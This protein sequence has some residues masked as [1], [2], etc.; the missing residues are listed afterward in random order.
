[1]PRAHRRLGWIRILLWV[2]W[3]VNVVAQ[4]TPYLGTPHPVPGLIEAEHYDLGGEGVAY[5]GLGLLTTNS[6]VKVKFPTGR[7]GDA[8]PQSWSNVVLRTGEWLNFSVQCQRDGHY[9]L[10]VKASG[11]PSYQERNSWPPDTFNTYT[12]EARVHFDVDGQRATEEIHL[13]RQD[14]CPRIWMSAGPHQVRLVVDLVSDF[15]EHRWVDDT[16]WWTYENGWPWFSF[17]LD[18]IQLRPA[19]APLFA[20]PVAG[21]QNGFQDGTGNEAQLGAFP[22]LIGEQPDGDLVVQDTANAALRV[23]S[24]DGHVRTLAGAPGSPL[25]DGVGSA[26]GFGNLLHTVLVPEGHLL[27]VESDGIRSDRVRRVE[28]D[29]T[30]TTLYR[31]RPEITVSNA[32]EGTTNV[33]VPLSRVI[34]LSSGKFRVAGEYTRD[35]LTLVYHGWPDGGSLEYLTVTRC[36]S[37]DLM[38]GV[39]TL[40]EI[41]PPLPLAEPQEWSDGYRR[42][43]GLHPGIIYK[44]PAGFMESATPDAHLASVLRARDGTFFCVSLHNSRQICRLDPSPNASRLVVESIGKGTISATPARMVQPDEEIVLEAQP[45]TRFSQFLGWSDGSTENPR[46]LRLPHDIR[47]TGTFGLV[48]PEPIGVRGD[49]LQIGADRS[50]QMGVVG[51]DPPYKYRVMVS[52]DLVHWNPPPAGT[53]VL[54]RTGLYSK[55]VLTAT[56]P[57]TWLSVPY[58]GSWLYVSL[59]VLDE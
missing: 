34:L 26:A 39:A 31:G 6:G 11:I 42:E 16:G 47:L 18:S 17:V 38:G 4:P 8:I 28:L 46:T 23:I 37:F 57:I 10:Q 2:G 14:F 7:P 20:T 32:F 54:F 43:S 1:M 33:V 22:L 27:T 40:A 29:G 13:E 3:A 59:E 55:D 58:I 19:L 5:H 25:E 9:S 49:K 30:V 51:S 45:A 56:S 41:G 15:F 53:T 36:A 35:E 12:G 24:R 21:G 48:Y 52:R 44:D 50:F